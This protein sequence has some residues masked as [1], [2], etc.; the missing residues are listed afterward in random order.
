MMTIQNSHQIVLDSEHVAPNQESYLFA[1]EHSDT[2]Q[3]NAIRL[4]RRIPLGKH[5]PDKCEA[6]HKWH[7]AVKDMLNG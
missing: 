6:V 3:D 7:Q 4:A 2:L 1:S 5:T